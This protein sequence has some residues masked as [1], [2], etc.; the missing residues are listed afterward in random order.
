MNDA[1][2]EPFGREDVF[3]VPRQDVAVDPSRLVER[4]GRAFVL[5]K[6]AAESSDDSFLRVEID[7]DFQIGERANLL[8]DY[9]K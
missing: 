6:V 1:V 2:G 9:L 4:F 3:F 7:E 5:F 8:K